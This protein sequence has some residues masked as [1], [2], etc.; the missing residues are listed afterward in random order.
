ML[1][2]LRAAW[3]NGGNGSPNEADKLFRITRYASWVPI[4]DLLSQ[5][6][7]RPEVCVCGSAR[8]RISWWGCQ[9]QE[10]YLVW[11]VGNPST[12]QHTSWSAARRGGLP[13]FVRAGLACK[14]KLEMAPKRSREAGA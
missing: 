5:V 8:L 11:C 13:L 10:L 9:G 7:P 6:Y 12:C 3:V 14:R 2:K 4:A 1:T